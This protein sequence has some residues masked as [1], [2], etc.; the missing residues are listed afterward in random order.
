MTIEI[1]RTTIL[2]AAVAVAAIT[3]KTATIT[4]EPARDRQGQLILLSDGTQQFVFAVSG[5][6]V[7]EAWDKFH[8]RNGVGLA[9]GEIPHPSVVLAVK[10]AVHARLQALKLGLSSDGI[11]RCWEVRV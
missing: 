6:D 8:C 4:I 3:A 5:P 11:I 7:G 9:P 1:R 10:N 2:D